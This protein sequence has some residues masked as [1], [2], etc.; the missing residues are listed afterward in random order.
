[1]VEEL[2]KELRSYGVL[3][4]SHV[5]EAFLRI[6]RKDFM[7]PDMRGLAYADTALPIGWGQTI[8]Q[9]FV[10]AFMIER[11]EPR[12]G[13]KILDVGAGSGWTT[14][15]LAHIAGEKGK[16]IALEVIEG[17][18]EFGKG[19]VAKYHFIEKGFVE[20]LCQ[21]GSKGYS[22]EAPFDGI[23]VS[24]SLPEKEIPRAWREQLK[25]GGKIVVSIRESVWVFSKN[26]DGTFGETEYP[27]FVFVPFV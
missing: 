23:L 3:K 20:F 26:E 12:Q 17:L 11:L 4:S 8:S 16:V 10:V 7:P 5:I 6:D 14:A 21:D 13:D 19:N 1:V 15:L 24:A 2:V 9:P 22:K 25:V 27:G 18:A